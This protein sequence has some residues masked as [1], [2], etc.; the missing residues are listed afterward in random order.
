MTATPIKPVQFNGIIR[1]DSVCPET[2]DILDNVTLIWT[3]VAQC[4]KPLWQGME[5][6]EEIKANYKSV[7]HRV[8]ETLELMDQII[9]SD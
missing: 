8:A 4:D 5:F 3:T 6:K 9:E 1:G 7:R 2:R